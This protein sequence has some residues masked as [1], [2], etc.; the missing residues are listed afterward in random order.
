MKAIITA[1]LFF[2]NQKIENTFI[3]MRLNYLIEGNQY[4][5]NK[6]THVG[7]NIKYIAFVCHVK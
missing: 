1:F 7:N 4:L 6:H 2:L 5:S 3:A